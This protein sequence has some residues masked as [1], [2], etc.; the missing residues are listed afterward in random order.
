MLE[1]LIA[2][3]QVIA[4]VPPN[5]ELRLLPLEP[6]WPTEPDV[7]P[8]DMTLSSHVLAVDERWW[9]LRP[10]LRLITGDTTYAFVNFLMLLT[11]SLELTVGERQ[12]GLHVSAAIE[13]LTRLQETTYKEC[14]FVKLALITCRCAWRQY[15]VE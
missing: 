15:C 10:I 4:A 2:N 8:E 14:K 11:R 9:F 1:A 5:A 7:L 12:V 13:G 3:L 6:A